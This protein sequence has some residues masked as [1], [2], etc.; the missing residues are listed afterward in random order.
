MSRKRAHKT[1]TIEEK[2][3]VLKEIDQNKSYTALSEKYGIGR[4][5]ICDIKLKEVELK[6]YYRTMKE[7]GMVQEAKVMKC[8]KD[9][10]L[11]KALFIW[12]KQKPEDGIPLAALF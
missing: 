11:E 10:E 1:L 6:G 2:I 7:M 9:I 12:F 8:E 5:T 3:K 4:S